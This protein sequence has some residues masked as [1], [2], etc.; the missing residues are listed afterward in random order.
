M[1]PELIPAV[2]QTRRAQSGGTVATVHALGE[3]GFPID[4]YVYGHADAE[5]AVAYQGCVTWCR[6]NGYHVDPVLPENRTHSKRKAVR[7]G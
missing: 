7:H 3:D 4:H 5:K 1:H 6:Y 2:I